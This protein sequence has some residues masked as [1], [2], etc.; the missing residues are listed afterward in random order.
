MKNEEK[1]PATHV[2]ANYSFSIGNLV[3][4]APGGLTLKKLE[5]SIPVMFVGEIVID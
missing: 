3:L 1:P 2:L 4:T 5:G